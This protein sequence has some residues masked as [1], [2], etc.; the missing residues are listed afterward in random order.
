MP[1]ERNIPSDQPQDIVSI[2]IL[3]AG[4][5]I[6]AAYQVASVSVTSVLNR[7]ASAKVVLIDGDPAEETFSASNG[8]D[9]VPGKEIEIK[10]GYHGDNTSLFKGIIIK[11]SIKI[12]GNGNSVLILDCRHAAIKM[13]L[14]R[15]SRYFYEKSDSEVMEE[16]LGDAGVPAQVT[17]TSETHKALI[18]YDST[19]WDFVLARAEANGLICRTSGSDLLIEAPDTA[20][21]PVLSLIYG[22]TIRE[23]DAEIDA[24]HQL[25]TVTA[26]SWDF[27]NQEKIEAVGSDPG[28]TLPGNLSVSDLSQVAAP[29]NWAL[30]HGGSLNTPEIQAWADAQV[31]RRQLAKVQGRARFQ[32]FAAMEPGMTVDLQGLGDRFNGKAYVGGVFHH[33]SRGDWW[34]DAQ[35]GFRPEWF[36]EDYEIT[37]PEAGGLLAAVRGLQIGVVSQ[38]ESDP[39]G[40]DRILVRLPIISPEDEGIWAR[41]ASLDAG[42]NRGAFFRPEIDDEVIVGFL[43]DDPRH[44]VVLGMLN[45]S[46]KPAPIPGSD[47][48]HEKGF[49][50]RS[51]MKMIFNDDLVSFTVETPGGRKFILDDDAGTITLE[52]GDGNKLVMESS[53]ISLESSGDI[54]IKAGGDLNL[55]GTNINMKASAQL[56]GEGGA[57]SEISSSATTVIKGAL[58]QIN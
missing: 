51:E 32:G 35:L 36:T 26:Y 1:N 58:V 49:V 39:D 12:K 50:T 42:E 53:G 11:H 31:L 27:A 16:I 20:Q 44:P 21:E 47:D 33:I 30:R 6:D 2:S 10:A 7:I 9:F 41:V 57:G 55:E 25:G 19:D 38:L 22:A 24:R 29:D 43:N 40:E 14:G 46:A 5:E 4:S 17:S 18:Q 8:N 15:N 23:L 34:T 45:S 37:P 56:K 52:D 28:I 3:I 48:N 13:T 54:N